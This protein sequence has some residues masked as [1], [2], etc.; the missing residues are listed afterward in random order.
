LIVGA[1]LK[2]N[3]MT[4]SLFQSGPAVSSGS[5]LQATLGNLVQQLM[6]R[7]EAAA[8]SRLLQKHLSSMSPAMLDDVGMGHDLVNG[9]NPW[10]SDCPIIGFTVLGG[11]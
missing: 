5:N 6:S 11:K 9:R 1:K 7:H 3:Q 8:A 10:R 2:V 4:I